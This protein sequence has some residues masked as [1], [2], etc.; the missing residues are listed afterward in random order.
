MNAVDVQNAEAIEV[1]KIASAAQ[2]DKRN[3]LSFAQIVKASD[4][5]RAIKAE[6]QR[7]NW[8]YDE[9]A[10]ALTAGCGFKVG[11]SNAKSVLDAIG[12]IV[13]KKELTPTDERVAALERKVKELLVELDDVKAFLIREFNWNDPKH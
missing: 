3:Y 5:A 9:W 7:G 8:T 6:A 2:D 4:R 1:L 12:V 11:K 10:A 13:K